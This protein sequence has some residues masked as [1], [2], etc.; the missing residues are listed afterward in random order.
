MMFANLSFFLSLCFGKWRQES[1]H[2]L[3]L[4]FNF[5]DLRLYLIVMITALAD[6]YPE[7]KT[8]WCQKK[9]KR[10]RWCQ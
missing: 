6:W 3:F 9:K 10:T 5:R 7:V 1:A 8:R 2:F 4:R